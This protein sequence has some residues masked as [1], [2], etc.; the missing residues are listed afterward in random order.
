LLR[1]T[2]AKGF[3]EDDFRVF[4]E[5]CERTGLDPFARQIYAIKR[6][7]SMT[8]QVSIDGFRLI[9][10]RSGRYE[11]QVGPY[12][13][14][15]DGKWQEVWLSNLPPVAA[16]VGVMKKGFRQPLFAVAR[17]DSYA[18]NT[19]LWNRMP[20]LMLAKVAEAL[21][22]R[23]A[24]PAELS[25]L[26]THDEMAQ[27]GDLGASGGSLS[28][29]AAPPEDAAG[30]PVVPPLAVAS[31]PFATDRVS[32]IIAAI[33]RLQKE[34]ALSPEEMRQAT[35]LSTLRGLSAEAL[36]DALSNIQEAAIRKAFHGDT[37]EEA[38]P[39]ESYPSPSEE[40]S[41]A[42]PSG[43]AGESDSL[44][45]PSPREG[46][47]EADA[48][49]EDPDTHLLGPKTSHRRSSRGASKSL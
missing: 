3:S 11:G 44:R 40:E 9:A 47:R 23:R 27:A 28:V 13:C 46:T 45:P 10:E 43:N 1:A 37:A 29:L 14:G 36:E 19:P 33:F 24:F 48:E 31:E 30:E 32:E 39:E 16:K 34:Y 20:D 4:V 2:L 25:G 8:P 38:A 41:A 6:G 42:H 35:G 12:W 22:L 7:N 17:W 49:P 18:Q 5:I 26:Y 15:M 21:A